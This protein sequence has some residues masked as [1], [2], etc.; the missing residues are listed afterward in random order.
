[1]LT[2]LPM[3][4]R[5]LLRRDRFTILRRNLG[6]ALGF[7]VVAFLIFLIPLAVVVTMPAA[8]AGSVVLVRTLVPEP[9]PEPDAA[10]D[11]SPALPPE[12]R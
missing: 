10:A 3:E 4:R 2:G 1:E 9:E 7:G 8:V 11:G 12:R 6:A 5:G